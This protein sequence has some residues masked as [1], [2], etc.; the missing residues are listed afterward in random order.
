M[1][2]GIIFFLLLLLAA[3]AQIVT[4]VGGPRDTTPPSV[5]KE[6]P[7]NQSLFFNSKTIKLTFD[8][9]VVLANPTENIFFSPPLKNT[10]TYLLKG[11]SLIIKLNDTLQ[12]NKT[13]NI[14]FTNAIKDYTEGNPLAI[15]QYSFSTGSYIDTFM[16]KGQ[17]VDALTTSKV[18]DALVLLYDRNIDSL[19]YSEY[20]T[21][22]TKSQ[23][24]GSFEFRHIAAGDYKIIALKDINNNFLYDLMTEGIAFSDDPISAIAMKEEVSDTIK[25][26]SDSV[27]VELHSVEDKLLTL[28]FFITEDTIQ[29][30]L[31]INTPQRDVYQIPYK[32]PITDYVVKP[33]RDTYPDYL[34]IK[35][36]TQDTLTWFFKQPVND[37]L[38]YEITVNNTHKDTITLNPYKAPVQRGRAK[39]EESNPFVISNSH[40]GN[41]YQPLT[42][43]FPFP[44]LKTEEFPVII[45]TNKKSGGDTIIK[46]FKVEE[47][48]V[49]SL[50]LPFTM[51]E[52][53][54]YTVIIRD[55]VFTTVNG[56]TNDS[57]WIKFNSKSEKDYGNLM[58]IYN[59]LNP[60]ID[61][62][63]TLESSKGAVIQEDIIKKSQT[64]SYMHLVPGDYK[65]KVV[66][67][68]NKNGRWDT[69]NYRLKQQPEKIYFFEK[70]ITIRGFWDLEEEMHLGK[71]E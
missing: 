56:F 2:N 33:F 46:N 45:M 47:D 65:I 37:T 10:P 67:D 1:K 14:A 19:P 11:K 12:S 58:M 3:C 62:I 48:F 15:Y 26:Q 57:V 30:L 44:I 13:Y 55:S 71:D 52:K 69:G 22:L 32:K 20:P 27:K 9:Y 7:E 54:P 41:L 23:K 18:A 28:N 51:E 31:K 35:S 6:F 68:R 17:V 38:I 61:Y 42:L 4:P 34:E 64:I 59:V 24:D 8:E 29:R 25:V 50:S 16:I 43:N 5:V 39:K 63:I 40:A 36:S 66:E 70:P 53:V 21:Y 60:S 49:L